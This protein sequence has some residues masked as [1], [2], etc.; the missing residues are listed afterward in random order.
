MQPTMK[1]RWIKKP[2]STSHD[3]QVLNGYDDRLVL[4]QLWEG[5]DFESTS[6]TPSYK[7]EWRD[8]PIEANDGA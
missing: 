5:K 4:Q 7:S 8:I 3:P 2:S 1:L 6:D